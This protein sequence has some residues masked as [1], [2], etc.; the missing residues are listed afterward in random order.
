MNED[1][2]NRRGTRRESDSVGDLLRQEAAR[3]RPLFSEALH[4]RILQR[5]PRS[6]ALPGRIHVREPQ[7]QEVGQSAWWRFRWATALAALAVAV[8]VIG[9]RPDREGDRLESVVVTPAVAGSATAAAAADPGFDQVPTFDELEAGVREGVS[10]LAA[11]LLDVP[12]WRTLA[13]F[14]AAGFFGSEPAP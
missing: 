6:P 9:P 3:E 10:T 14:D 12:E 8:A 4:G 11:T 2:M 7:P 1:A 5:L 13:D